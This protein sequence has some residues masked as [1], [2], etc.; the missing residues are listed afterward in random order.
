MPNM[1]NSQKHNIE[2]K[3][4]EKADIKE[5]LLLCLYLYEV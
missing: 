1:H 3:K 4:A 2:H 5:I